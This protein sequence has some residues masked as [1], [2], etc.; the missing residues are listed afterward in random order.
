MRLG[1]FEKNDLWRLPHPPD[2]LNLA[3]GALLRFPH[4]K[5]CLAD[6]Q[7]QFEDE[8]MSYLG[9]LA[10]PMG[11]IWQALFAEWRERLEWMLGNDGNYF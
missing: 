10:D 11:K 9:R 5:E 8:L 1:L 7:R 4:L 6:K 3:P 2:S